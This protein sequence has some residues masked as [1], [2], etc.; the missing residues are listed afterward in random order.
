MNN[1]KMKQNANIEW[2]KNTQQIRPQ[3][4]DYLKSVSHK[5]DG[6]SYQKFVDIFNNSNK[7]KLESK[8]Q[9]LKDMIASAP[10]KAKPITHKAIKEQTIALKEQTIALNKK[11]VERKIKAAEKI[12]KTLRNTV[13]AGSRIVDRNDKYKHSNSGSNKI[14]RYEKKI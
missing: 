13:V 10:A 1:I 6:R 3:L 5:I 4:Y 8:Y 12:V 7:P 14:Y 11:T 2:G 9:E